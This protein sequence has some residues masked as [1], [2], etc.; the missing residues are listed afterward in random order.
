MY[1]AKMPVTSAMECA[2]R[3]ERLEKQG[4]E[5]PAAITALSGGGRF[6]LRILGGRVVC[7]H[8]VVRTQAHNV[9]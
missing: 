1:C 5:A 4:E 3:P 8:E 2:G 6:V 9:P 7:R